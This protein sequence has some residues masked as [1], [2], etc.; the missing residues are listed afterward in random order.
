MFA[1]KSTMGSLMRTI[2]SF[3]Y[4]MIIVH[5][6]RV[7]PDSSIDSFL[8]SQ[9]SLDMANV[10]QPRPCVFVKMEHAPRNILGLFVLRVPLAPAIALEYMSNCVLS[11]LSFEHAVFMESGIAFHDTSDIDWLAL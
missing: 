5:V 2:A 1:R 7:T 11:G 10:H 3:T 9:C 4:P 6:G 8:L